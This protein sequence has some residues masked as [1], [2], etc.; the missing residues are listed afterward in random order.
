VHGATVLGVYVAL[1]GF[2]SCQIALWIIHKLAS[3]MR[4]AK[5]V[6]PALKLG[7]VEGCLHDRHPAHGVGQ[8]SA[9]GLAALTGS[10]VVTG[11]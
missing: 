10:V 11:M 1:G 6:Q 9:V 3:A 7:L 2:G 8:F 4:A 5:G